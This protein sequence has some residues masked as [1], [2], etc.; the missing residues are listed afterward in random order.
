MISLNTLDKYKN[1]GNL[2]R[3]FLPKD[4]IMGEIMLDLRHKQ[5][6]QNSEYFLQSLFFWIH[7]FV[8]YSKEKDVQDLKFNRT[9]QEIWESKKASGCTDYAL[10]YAT[11]ARTLDIPTTILHTAEYE[12]LQR[13]K[14]SEDSTIH[15]G[16]TFCECYFNEKWVLVDPTCKRIESSYNSNKIELSYQVGGK[17]IFIPYYRGLDFGQK[18][19]VETHN[20]MMDKLCRELKM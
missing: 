15:F 6:E 5:K 2:T 18:Q 3:P 17:S 7:H 10:L 4:F 11:F 19:N 8:K 16:H 20:K 13:L 14:N 1:S 12:W 9:A